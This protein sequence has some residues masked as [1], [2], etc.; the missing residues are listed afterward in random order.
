MKQSGFSLK[1]QQIL[2]TV[3]ILAI[4]GLAFS[5]MPLRDVVAE[6]QVAAATIDFPALQRQATD[7]LDRLHRARTSGAF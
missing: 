3:L 6:R 7:A 1:A 4:G 2:A 5:A